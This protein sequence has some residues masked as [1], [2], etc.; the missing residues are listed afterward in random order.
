MFITTIISQN[1]QDNHPNQQ[2]LGLFGNS[3][4]SY[5]LDFYLYN[6]KEGHQVMEAQMRTKCDLWLE[7]FPGQPME[8]PQTFAAICFST[9]VNDI[10]SASATVA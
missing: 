2:R 9:E 10:L 5:A 6:Q 3:G 7:I 4:P 8:K 1:K